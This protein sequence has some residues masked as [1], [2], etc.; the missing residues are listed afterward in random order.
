MAVLKSLTF[1]ALNKPTANP[2]LDRDTRIIDRL[3]EQKRL[4]AD[5]TYMR[6]VRAWSKDETGKKTLFE[7]KQR[8]LPWWME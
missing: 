1:A 4:L 6:S 5:S 7:T 2:T 3:E 8:V